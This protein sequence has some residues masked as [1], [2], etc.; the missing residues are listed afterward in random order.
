[1]RRSVGRWHSPPDL[2]GGIARERVS[3]VFQLFISLILSL[4]LHAGMVPA[5]SAG[6]PIMKPA[7]S[8]GG[9]I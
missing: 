2:P 4:G 5:D 6:G 9:P 7:D 8:A 3:H 1:M